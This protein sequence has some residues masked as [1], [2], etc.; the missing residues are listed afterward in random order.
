MVVV[1]TFFFIFFSIA[2]ALFI[3]QLGS[4]DSGRKTTL[5]I[6][7]LFAITIESIIIYRTDFVYNLPEGKQYAPKDPMQSNLQEYEQKEFVY[8]MNKDILL[9]PLAEY[10]ITGKVLSKKDHRKGN[11]TNSYANTFFLMDIGL[12]WKDFSDSFYAM[13]DSISFANRFTYLQTKWDRN[14]PYYGQYEKKINPYTSNNHIIPANEEVKKKVLKF[15]I[16]QVINMKGY[17]VAYQHKL[18][19][20]FNGKSSMSRTDMTNKRVNNTTCE[21]FYVTDAEIVEKGSLF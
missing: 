16:G 15:N 8:E 17:L 10:D 6:F 21:I 3:W 11:Y 2:I 14:F 18:K 9:T 4:S 7:T 13:H 5:I 1:L 12:G 19:S 20:W